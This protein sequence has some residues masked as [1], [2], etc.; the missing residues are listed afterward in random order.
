M[1]I[2][3]KLLPIIGLLYFGL[4]CFGQTR[5]VS[6]EVATTNAIQTVHQKFHSLTNLAATASTIA[7]YDANKKLGTISASA[8]RTILEV[9]IFDSIDPGAANIFPFWDDTQNEV[10]WTSNT[11]LRT[12]LGIDSNDAVTFGAVT[13]D[14]FTAGSTNMVGALAGKQPLH[15]NLTGLA[16]LAD[17][18]ADR[19]VFWDESANAFAFLTAGSGLTITTT[20]MTSS[21]GGGGSA[22]EGTMVNSGASTQYAF[23]YYTDETGTNLAPS[24]ITTDATKTNL[25]AGGL[26]ANVLVV[27]NLSESL[28]NLGLGEE[29]TPTFASVIIGTTNAAG[30]LAAKAEAAATTS[31]LALKGNLSGG[32]TWSGAQLLAEG[33]SIELDAAGSADGAWSG[34]SRVGTAGATLAFGDLI[35][36]DPTDSRWELADANSASGADGDARGIIG[37][38]V[39]AA[40]SDGSVTRILLQGVVRAD[41][42]FPSL[43]INGPIYVSETAGDITQTSPTTEDNVVRILGAAWTADEIHFAPDRVWTVYDAP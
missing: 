32:N 5:G 27:T 13:G 14:S 16:A 33:A 30:A 4:T 43:T 42:V 40:A 34:I 36:L 26:N 7:G 20:T 24:L 21:G 3:R 37:I 19:I 35:Y 1:K 8:A 41:A 18:G 25:N 12:L 22:P 2:L 23:P 29:D 10:D 11:A 31:S 38:C 28:S 17:P 9:P 6:Y 39:L 15:A